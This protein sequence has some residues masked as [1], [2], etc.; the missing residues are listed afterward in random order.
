[1]KDN[2]KKCIGL[3]VQIYRDDSVKGIFYK[4][5]DVAVIKFMQ[6]N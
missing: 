3:F 5:G 2:K 4:P 6:L 1:M